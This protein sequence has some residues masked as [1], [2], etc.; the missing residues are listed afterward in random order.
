[1]NLSEELIYRGFQAETTIKNPSSLN[2]RESKKFYWG[3]DPSA[4]S[5]TIGNLAALMMC[6]CFI[7]HGYEPYLLV[8]GA[9]GQIGDPKENGERDLKTLDE[10]EHNKSC[11]KSQI[12][13]VI[14]SQNITMVDNY[15]WFKNI[16]YLDFLREVG[17]AFSMTQLLD[18]QF[19][20]NRIGDGGSGISY[21]EFSYTLI[22]GYDFLH[23][24]RE[25]G[26]SLQLCGADQYGNCTSGIHLIKRLE[27]ADADVWSTPLVIDPNT[28]RKFG[29][30]EG[31]AIWLASTD[32]GSGNYT[33]IFDFYQF[34]LNQPDSSIEYLLK[35][36]TLLDKPAIESILEQH[37]ASPEQRLAQKTLA[38]CA[39]EIVH[40]K[41]NA[42]AIESL[43][44]LLFDRA[45]DFT[46]FSSDEILEFANFLPTAPRGLSLV[47][48]L[49]TTNLAESKKKAREFIAAGAISINGNKVTEDI[50][51]SQ[52]AIIK[53]GKNKFAIVK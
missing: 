36:Y 29:K 17:K 9:T 19:V 3:A 8:G 31:N 40:G 11:I 47:D 4:D 22:Q 1:M 13:R 14:N 16:N 45:T 2:T 43:T 10:V 26:V 53:K 18:R 24:F 44:N 21:A 33:P 41:E 42:E 51:I 48:I 39:T 5:L 34:W 28:G 6:A 49:T 46:S 20:Q 25:H 23:L 12:E 7:R 32:N 37:F 15:D 52:I 50:T 35:I 30:S 38:R 27:N